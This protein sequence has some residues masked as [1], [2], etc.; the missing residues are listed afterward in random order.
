MTHTGRWIPAYLN[1]R[2]GEPFKFVSEQA[3]QFIR[4]VSK[5]SEQY[6]P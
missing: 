3:T 2:W 4:S 5:A 1:E 6:F